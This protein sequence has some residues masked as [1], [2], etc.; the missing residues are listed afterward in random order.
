MKKTTI[1]V[2]LVIAFFVIFATVP[3]LLLTRNVSAEQEQQ[4]RLE[5]TNDRTLVVLKILKKYPGVPKGVDEE[6]AYKIIKG[7]RADYF[8]NKKEISYEFSFPVTVLTISQQKR[9]VYENDKWKLGKPE[10]AV[11][12]TRGWA[13]TVLS[14]VSSFLLVFMAT[15][16]NQ[17]KKIGFKKLFTFYFFLIGLATIVEMS[18]SLLTMDGSM[19]IGVLAGTFLVWTRGVYV[20][21]VDKNSIIFLLMLIFAT[22]VGGFSGMFVSK[23]DLWSNY[24]F[25][26][27]GLC[28]FS[29]LVCHFGFR[30]MPRLYAL[31]TQKPSLKI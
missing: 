18:S 17:K 4:I 3:I 6:I 25:F 2:C 30:L 19:T 10:S 12:E 21:G 15:F 5:M 14:V 11:T 28:I 8:I 1:F 31:T 7:E 13:I 23:I 27:V 20:S 26:I 29:Y 9:V 16:L 24:S 22:C